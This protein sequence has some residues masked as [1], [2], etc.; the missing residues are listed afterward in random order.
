MVSKK[1]GLSYPWLS[2]SIDQDYFGEK[3]IR[4][5]VTGLFQKYNYFVSDVFI[6]IYPKKISLKFLVFISKKNKNSRYCA[7]YLE[8]IIGITKSILALK[9]NKNVSISIRIVNDA[10]DDPVILSKLLQDKIVSNP[11]RYRVILKRLMD[12]FRK[13]G[14]KPVWWRVLENR[15][16][17]K[18]GNNSLYSKTRRTDSLAIQKL[19]NVTIKV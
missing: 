1:L 7:L 4:E 16:G 15:R 10:F 6:H 9:F 3:W 8:R 19:K 2:R 5:F 11:F 17:S 12:S 13:K 18:R 14:Y